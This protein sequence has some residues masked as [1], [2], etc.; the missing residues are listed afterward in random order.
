MGLM[1]LAAGKGATILVRATGHQ[2][3]EALEALIELVN[4]GFGEDSEPETGT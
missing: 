3:R 2:A 4:S 1:T